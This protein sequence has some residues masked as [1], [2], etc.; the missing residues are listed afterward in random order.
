MT[1]PYLHNGIPINAPINV[2]GPSTRAWSGAASSLLG[3]NVYSQPFFPTTNPM[4]DYS[5][6]KPIHP[7]VAGVNNTQSQLWMGKERDN[8]WLQLPVCPVFYR[9]YK[10]LEAGV[11]G[12]MNYNLADPKERKQ[13]ECSDPNCHS[14]FAHPPANVMKHVLTSGYVVCCQS[15]VFATKNGTTAPHTG[16]VRGEDKCRL[17]VSFYLNNFIEHRFN[18]NSSIYESFDIQPI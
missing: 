3:Q 9:F 6:V 1:S 16:C 15:F 14:G 8:T 18:G 17:V 11:E 7:N 12:V 4:L 13:P 5:L 2:I 10:E